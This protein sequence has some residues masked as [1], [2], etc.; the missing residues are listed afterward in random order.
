MSKVADAFNSVRESPFIAVEF[1]E[2][3]ALVIYGAILLSPYYE[4]MGGSV[5]Q[6]LQTPL[7]GTL[8]AILYII[9][10]LISL[11]GCYHPSRRNRNISTWFLFST[12]F[13]TT[14]LRLLTVGFL[15][16]LWV[17]TLLLATIAIIDN[18]N[19]NWKPS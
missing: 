5:M 7:I 10:G 2:G 6:I 4:P 17:W 11:W 8:I 13:F 14:L 3:V 19:I 16:L 1:I 12:F 18:W 9:T 15:P